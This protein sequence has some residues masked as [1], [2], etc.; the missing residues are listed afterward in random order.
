MSTPDIVWRPDPKAMEAT[1]VGRFMATHGI[2]SVEELRERIFE[3]L[4][5]TRGFGV[6]LGLPLVRRIMEQ[7]HGGVEVR[8]GESEG[9]C[10]VLWL[11]TRRKE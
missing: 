6:G 3:P 4:F 2:D 8:A 7:H 11:P 5:S 1:R 9:A 10:F